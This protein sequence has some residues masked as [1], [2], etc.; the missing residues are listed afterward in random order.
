MATAATTTTAVAT[1]AATMT[2]TSAAILGVC[3]G[4]ITN[5]VR[6]QCQRCRKD[7][8]DG[9][10]QQAFFEQHDESPLQ[11]CISVLKSNA[12]TNELQLPRGQPA[13]QR[14]L[15]GD[16]GAVTRARSLLCQSAFLFCGNFSHVM[17]LVFHTGE[18]MTGYPV[19]GCRDR[20]GEAPPF[21]KCQ[22][23]LQRAR[24]RQAS[25]A[26]ACQQRYQPSCSVMRSC[27][28]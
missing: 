25:G 1:T 26:H 15:L 12:T 10:R 5:R 4:E 6:H 17:R 23:W 19:I 3:A 16:E 28:W 18:S 24:V 21:G 27:V 20:S 8:T 22:R 7:A 11:S 9:Q 2:A 14:P 13:N